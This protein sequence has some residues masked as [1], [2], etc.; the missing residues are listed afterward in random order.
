MT[1]T[2]VYIRAK[3]TRTHPAASATVNPG[4]LA[5]DGGSAWDQLP[6]LSVL[7]SC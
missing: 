5:P 7:K 3:K 2:S 4:P 1:F 6:Q